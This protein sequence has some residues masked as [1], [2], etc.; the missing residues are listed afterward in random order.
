LQGINPEIATHIFDVFLM[1]GEIVICTL[2]IKFIE[3]SKDTI[4]KLDED[5]F[6]DFIKHDLP[7]LCLEANP[8]YELLDFHYCMDSE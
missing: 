7:R 1:E 3:H 4:L 8:M 2:F 6:D 5:N